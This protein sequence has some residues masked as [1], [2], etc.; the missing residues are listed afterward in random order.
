MLRA[1][2]H[3]E[4]CQSPFRPVRK[5]PQ[6]FCSV[7]C[8]KRSRPQRDE[9][10]RFLS[11][12]HR[13]E[14]G[15]LLWTGHIMPNGYAFFV[16]GSEV[17]GTKHPEYVHRWIYEKKV[18]PIP[19]GFTID[20]ICHTNDPSCLGGRNC[21]H[22]RCVDET[23]MEPVTR[24]VNTLRGNSPSAQNYR[25]THCEKGHLLAGKNLVPSKYGRNCR[26][27]HNA[28]RRVGQRAG[29]ENGALLSAAI[30]R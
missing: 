4:L 15:C 3:C 21:L 29:R 13:S 11:R 30:G 27:C 14:N 10:E 2:Q 28:R 19:E 17:A 16:I 24:G 23:H 12:C 6:R 7:R 9:M 1:I 18:G 8:A 5:R 26:E 25:K 20:H 22:R